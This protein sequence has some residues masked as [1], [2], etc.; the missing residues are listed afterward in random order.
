MPESVPS[1]VP[2]DVT[3]AELERRAVAK[4]ARSALVR[5]LNLQA[6]Y[7][8]FVTLHWSLGYFFLFDQG[9]SLMGILV[10]PFILYFAAAVT[11]AALRWISARRTMRIG[12]LLRMATIVPFILW[13][14]P[15]GI[16][17]SMVLFGAAIVLFWVPYNVL[18]FDHR[19]KTRRAGRSA[20][21]SA[22][23]PFIDAFATVSAGWVIAHHGFQPLFVLAF[24]L[25][26]L[27]LVYVRTLELPHR[28]GRT[29]LDMV[30]HLRR[31][32][33]LRTMMFLNGVSQGVYWPAVP[34]ITLF[35]ITGVFAYAGFFGILG[36]VGA[37]GAIFLARLSDKAGRRLQYLLPFSAIAGVAH[38][39]SAFAPTL[40]VWGLSRG[41]SN[42]AT[43]LFDPFKNA[44]L[45][46]KAEGVLDLYVARE[47]LLNLGRVVGVMIV[48]VA[49]WFDHLQ[50]S[51]LI[52]GLV[53][54]FLP[55]LVEWKDLY[56]EER[57]LLKP[58]RSPWKQ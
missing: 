55:I 28:R 4:E 36:L 7:G 18:Y 3:P 50:M 10:V 45:L 47:L 57:Y 23:M 9:F 20:Y 41:L 26:V 38:L 12:I 32:R 56:P 14:G 13:P 35:F 40:L 43:T 33:G 52:P 21:Y 27:P 6:L 46:D 5:L 31:V 42:V 30:R 49:L 15:T 17:L 24:V 2:G 48:A 16:Y 44:I 1:E 53:S 29:K 54:L 19:D 11:V 51:M 58:F 25:G 22:V 37:L 39:A 34:L 8:L